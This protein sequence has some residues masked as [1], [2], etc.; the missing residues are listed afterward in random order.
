VFK[1]F[2][3]LS[4]ADQKALSDK[5]QKAAKRIL[6][7]YNSTEKSRREPVPAHVL[8]FLGFLRDK[9]MP[10]VKAS[11]LAGGSL[12]AIVLALLAGEDQAAEN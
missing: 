11:L 9:G 1:H 10:G 6:E 5:A 4:Q 8:R 7:I 12:P 2:D 3:Q